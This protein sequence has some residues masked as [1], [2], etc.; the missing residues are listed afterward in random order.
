MAPGQIP[1]REQFEES[2]HQRL[3]YI[4]TRD[5]RARKGCSGNGLGLSLVAAVADLHGMKLTASDN[6]PGLRMTLTF[7]PFPADSQTT[8]RVTTATH[9]WRS[10][11]IPQ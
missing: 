3:R 5:R 9:R 11:G 4:G 2:N 10:S 1:R 6:A 8:T 7:D